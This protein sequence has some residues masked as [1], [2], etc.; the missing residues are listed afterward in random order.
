MFVDFNDPAIHADPYA[1]YAW[2]REEHPVCWDGQRWLI[3]RYDDIV[4]LLNDPRISSA[5]TDA[6]FA[7]LPKAVQEELQPL[8]TIL[9][10]RMLLRDPPEHTRLRTLMT[11]AFSARALEGMRPRIQEICDGF[12]DR[13]HGR[14]EL[15]IMHDLA[16]LVPS[17]VI[18]SML[19]V[20][21]ADHALFTRWSADQ[22]RVY[23][24]IGT[25]GDRVTVMR[26]G[27]A[28]MLEMKAYLEAIM[29]ARR[30]DPRDDLIT[31][32]ITVEEQGDRLTS[33]EVI[34]MIIAILV[35]GN[36]ST[37]H[38]IGNAIYTLLHHPGDLA[39]LRAE[40]DLIRP[41]I[42][43]VMRYESPVQAT[44]RVAKEAIPIRDQT[45]EPGQNVAVL[46]GAANRDGAQFPAPD[47]FIID[48]QPNRHLTFAHGPHFCLG[49]ALARAEAQTAV[50]TAVQR[51]PNLALATDLVEWNP[52]FAFRSLT[53]LPVM[54]ST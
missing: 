38:L 2:L 25:A 9:N 6:T 50:L 14:G 53:A 43:E 44:S 49:G 37:A 10:S 45:I 46:F 33:D 16:T 27:Q 26:Q 42:E 1:T 36:N 7:V 17:Y 22:V 30:T 11:K 12:M 48:R 32:L 34:A 41:A 31:M 20:P 13:A 4:T 51:L 23:D 52:G 29:A 35:G 19:G 8:R 24:R 40:P 5:R 15:D 3:S 39:R 21:A 54:F 28:S 47:T 18:A